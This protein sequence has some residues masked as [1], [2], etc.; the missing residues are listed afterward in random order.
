[1]MKVRSMMQ[2]NSALTLVAITNDGVDK[3]GFRLGPPILERL[4]EFGNRISLGEIYV[5]ATSDA[6]KKGKK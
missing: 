4:K 1:V 5:Y 2:A 6:K 3:C